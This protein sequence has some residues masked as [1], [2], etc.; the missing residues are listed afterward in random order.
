MV[1]SGEGVG[2]SFMNVHMCFWHLVRVEAFQV[3]GFEGEGGI[4]YAG[5]YGGEE[6]ARNSN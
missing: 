1:T 5:P 2:A 4:K 6:Q 3:S